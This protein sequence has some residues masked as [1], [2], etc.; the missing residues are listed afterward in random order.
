SATFASLPSRGLHADP[1]SGPTNK[2][3]ARDP[4]DEFAPRS[5]PATA[6]RTSSQRDRPRARA[7]AQVARNRGTLPAS[8]RGWSENCVRP[9][10]ISKNEDLQPRRFAVRQAH[11]AARAG[12]WLTLLLAA[13]LIAAPAIAGPFSRLQVLLPGETA[14]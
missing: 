7:A 8:I 5:H 9:G 13:Q 10:R 1:R 2:A 3:A 6:S 4:P 12:V 14:A 11:R